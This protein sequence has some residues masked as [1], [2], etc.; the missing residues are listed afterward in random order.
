MAVYVAGTDEPDLIDESDEFAHLMER[1]LDLAVDYVT[2]EIGEVLTADADPAAISV[3]DVDAIRSWWETYVDDVLV[4]A[5]TR[6]MIDQSTWTVTQIFQAIAVDVIPIDAEL[7]T[8]IFAR[9][10]RNRLIEVGDELWTH[11]RAGITEG[12]AEGETIPQIA[13]R[14]SAAAGVTTP[15]ATMIARTEMLTARNAASYTTAARTGLNMRK[16]WLATA[17]ARTRQTHRDADGQIVDFN[18][19]FIVGAGRL[20]YPGDMNA[21]PEEGIMCRC[22]I[23][24]VFDEEDINNDNGDNF[25]VVAATSLVEE[26]TNNSDRQTSENFDNNVEQSSQE[27]QLRE[28]RVVP[29]SVVENHPDCET[30]YAVVKD[31]DGELMGC[32]ETFSGAEDQITAINISEA[33]QNS[34]QTSSTFGSD[35]HFWEGVLAV[36]DT[37]TGDGREFSL[38]SLTWP[39]LEETTVSLGW[40]YRRDHGGVP[41]DNVVTIGRVT[42]IWREDNVIYGRGY[43]SSKIPEGVDALARMG[44]VYDPGFLSGVS[45]DND[46]PDDP[47]GSTT[48]YVFPASCEIDAA[49]EE[50]YTPEKVVYHSHRIRA[51][52]LVDIPA[53]VQSKIYLTPTIDTVTAS[54]NESPI[55][56]GIHPPLMPPIEWFDAP[57]RPP[58]IGGIEIT[59]EGRIF[60]YLAPRNVA[61]RGISDRK[62]TVPMGDVDYSRYMS[63]P[64]FV[65]NGSGEKTTIATGSAT[66]DC[67][68]APLNNDSEAARDHYEN[69]CSIVASIRI[70]EDRRGVWVAGALMPDVTNAQILRIMASQFSGDWRPHK[71]KQGMRDFAGALLVPVP[72]FPV[73]HEEQYGSVTVASGVLESASAPITVTASGAKNTP[74]INSELVNDVRPA[75]KIAAKQLSASIGRD[76]KTRLSN[77]KK[78]ALGG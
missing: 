73:A 19:S 22:T 76:S 17:D 45:I 24:Y 55:D 77:A 29:Y 11:A 58:E 46:A 20:Q 72:G 43:I 47:F 53:F 25:P 34:S 35:K 42:H 10:S 9:A 54:A 41:G 6:G 39:D 63:R 16:Q 70:G 51:V 62:Q 68:H 31:D 56:L 67:G 66:M 33:E 18:D 2:D 78:I 40:M 7:A 3:E 61:H 30:P 49:G 21:P 14:V 60:G 23:V 64:R 12:L 13:D 26:T 1:G 75:Y 38:G 5:L 44:T 71:E 48:E 52:T 59:E 36:E 15:R 8:D 57:E 74:T 69:T 28:D 4:P 50:C 27:L 65:I 37:P 32:H